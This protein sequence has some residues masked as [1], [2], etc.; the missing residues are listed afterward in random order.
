MAEVSY[1]RAEQPWDIGPWRTAHAADTGIV[2]APGG[3]ERSLYVSSGMYVFRRPGP[4]WIQGIYATDDE[5]KQLP[6]AENSSGSVRYDRVVDKLLADGTITTEIKTGT[7]GAGAP[8]ALTQVVGGTWEESLGSFPVPSGVSSL[9]PLGV[10]VTD[11]RRF[12]PSLVTPVSSETLRPTSPRLLDE[13]VLPDGTRQRWTGAA[14]ATL[15]TPPELWTPAVR[16]GSTVWSLTAGST[17]SRSRAN[18]FVDGWS[19]ATLNNNGPS[20]QPDA[21]LP[22]PLP[23]YAA[24]PFAPPSGY[25]GPVGTFAYV[26]A[27]GAPV[28]DGQLVYGYDAYGGAA[29]LTFATSTS[30]PVSSSTTG[31]LLYTG[32]QWSLHCLWHYP[33]A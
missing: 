15:I 30:T 13:V 16:S 17:G 11:E 9:T 5:E 7:D 18:G 32:N 26:T 25:R 33:A 6:V 10:S 20:F 23:V 19:L 12:L 22:P 14:W 27:T 8:P 2:G 1:P 28:A 4:R 24:P 31:G 3:P 21:G 29:R